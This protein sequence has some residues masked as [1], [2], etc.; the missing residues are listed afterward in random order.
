MT[1]AAVEAPVGDL[2]SRLRPEAAQVAISGIDEIAKYGR[3]RQG[4]IPLWVGEGDM[5]TQTFINE[6]ATRSLAAG[7]TFYTDQRGIPEYRDAVARYVTKHY[8]NF[9]GAPHPAQRFFATIGGMHAFQLA[10]RMVAGAGDEVIV[11]TPAWPN[12]VAA[13]EVNGARAVCVPMHLAQSGRELAWSLD[14]AKLR[15]AINPRTRMI[16]INSPSNPLME[17]RPAS[18]QVIISIPFI[19][20][21]STKLVNSRTAEFAPRHSPI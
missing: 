14:L 16:F 17:W 15:E 19:V 1:T 4:L 6:A 20:M 5:P 7:E 10:V 9:D 11:P 3:G 12:V 13:A 21:P 8:G 2:I 18:F